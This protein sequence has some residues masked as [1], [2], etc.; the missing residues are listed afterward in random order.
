MFDLKSYPLNVS[1]FAATHD[2]L[3]APEDLLFLQDVL[4]SDSSETLSFDDFSHL[5]WLVAKQDSTYWL[6]N[7][8][9]SI[10]RYAGL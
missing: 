10:N 5:T 4:P 7:F 6:D 3:V 8:T 1:L 2:A 9:A